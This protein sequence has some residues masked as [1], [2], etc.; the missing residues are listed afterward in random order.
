MDVALT[1]ANMVKA[2]IAT[3]WLEAESVSCAL[4]GVT[5]AAHQ[6]EAAGRVGTIIREFGGALLADEAGMGKTYA[7]LAIAREY[8]AT[9]VVAPA[10][11]RGMWIEALAVTEGRSFSIEDPLKKVASV[12]A[13]FGE[14][15][16]ERFQAGPEPRQ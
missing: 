16:A 6:V 10:S 2:R 15:Y 9:T 12:D 4:G 8:R 5:L 3:A 7:A 13:M 11:L 14:R 1:R